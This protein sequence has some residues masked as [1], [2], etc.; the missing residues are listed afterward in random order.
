MAHTTKMLD[1]LTI[2]QQALLARGEIRLTVTAG[3]EYLASGIGNCAAVGRS[4]RMAIEALLDEA[5]S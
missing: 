1:Q 5:K 4:P 3:G 2:E